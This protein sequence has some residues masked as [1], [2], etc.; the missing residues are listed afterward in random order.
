[1]Y[2]S[3][4]LAHLARAGRQHPF[5][6]QNVNNANTTALS[7]VKPKLGLATERAYFSSWG[8]NGYTANN[9][10][11]STNS[12]AA[13]LAVSN[14]DNQPWERDLGLHRKQFR[15][16]AGVRRYSTGSRTTSTD[17]GTSV[18]HD[19]P[20]QLQGLPDLK[21][22]IDE[23]A[24]DRN[25]EEGTVN[26]ET[27]K[28][29]FVSQEDEPDRQDPAPEVE[30]TY[31][32]K[33]KNSLES[34]LSTRF[35]ARD[36]KSVH[37]I[38]QEAVKS[39]DD[40][41]NTNTFNWLFDAL[42]RLEKQDKIMADPSDQ[43]SGHN[44]T[45]LSLHY[46]SIMLER[47]IRPD[48][49]TFT[50]ILKHLVDH[51][52]DLMDQRLI[53]HA[54]KPFE[55]LPQTRFQ[56]ANREAFEAAKAVDAAGTALQIFRAS[57]VGLDRTYDAGLLQNLLDCCVSEGY[58]DHAVAIYDYIEQ[59]NT[60]K[61]ASMYGALMMTFEKAR[62]L[63]GA[64][65]TF[66]TWKK[67][68][69][70]LPPHDFFLMYDSLIRCYF[71][72]G[73]AAGGLRF[74]LSAVGEKRKLEAIHYI[75][76]V[77][78]FADQ[79]LF[80][81]GL[82]FARQHLGD[83][84]LAF[85]DAI[86]E[87]VSSAYL[88]GHYGTARE[89]YK[90]VE[91]L[92]AFAR[93]PT[94]AFNYLA[95]LTI[96]GE[97]DEAKAFVHDCIRSKIELR[98][99]H[100]SVLISKYFAAGRISDAFEMARFVGDRR[101]V[102]NPNE[103]N[104]RK[105]DI[106]SQLFT[107]DLLASN[108]LDHKTTALAIAVLFTLGKTADKVV[109]IQFLEVAK[110]ELDMK[111]LASETET[112]NQ[113]CLYANNLMMMEP[114]SSTAVKEVQ[115][116]AAPIISWIVDALLLANDTGL[117][118]EPVCN[119]DMIAA[120]NSLGL[121]QKAAALEETLE[122]V[123][124]SSTS[125][126]KPLPFH[127][128][129]F[130]AL[131]D[132]AI[133]RRLSVQLRRAMNLPD[134]RDRRRDFQPPRGS[135]KSILSAFT[136]EYAADRPAIY[137]ETYCKAIDYYGK[138]GDSESLQRLLD[139]SDRLLPAMVNSTRH[140]SAA[141]AIIYDRAIKAFNDFFDNSSAQIYH[142]KILALGFA[143][144][145]DAYGS[146]IAKMNENVI[147][148]GASRAHQLFEEAVKIGVVPTDFLY[149]TLI[150]KLAKARRN[151]DALRYFQQM[152]DSG[153]APNGVT[154]GTVINSCCRVG[155]TEDAEALL[156]EMEALPRRGDKI[157]PYN[158]LMQHFVQVKKDRVKAL[159]YW[160]K[161]LASAIPPTGHS[162]RL[163]IEVYGRLDPVDPKAAESVLDMMR[164]N[165]LRIESIHVAALMVMY[166]TKLNDTKKAQALFDHWTNA[167]FRPD[168]ILYQ[169]LIETHVRSGQFAAVERCLEQM[170]LHRVP[171]TAYIANLAIEAYAAQNR[172]E[173]ARKC[174]D[175][176]AP[177]GSGKHNHGLAREPSTYE[178][179]IK[180]Y[181]SVNMPEKNAEILELI[182]VQGYPSAV[183]EKMQEL[184]SQINQ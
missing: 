8:S 91:S 38:M 164:S 120:A 157:A 127:R 26:H 152:K 64:I 80:K 142:D 181:N 163:L 137:G 19:V 161:L 15:S 76:V 170:D 14:D 83:S 146:F 150:G 54:H 173:D 47:R 160:N 147:R 104:R 101:A 28:D 184:V 138:F 168:A 81:E 183:V 148:D 24:K 66:N 29:V 111:L 3:P 1:M 149:N 12:P 93:K 88:Q 44:N 155:Q 110:K 70:D 178:A 177:D 113:L 21:T 2:K 130:R 16:I 68:C 129:I 167:E 30:K 105:L 180:A 43:I 85:S 46:Y 60:P 34:E 103:M 59:T 27:L 84:P 123:R 9:S 50:R 35:V 17:S 79:A 158:T 166:G 124:A 22:I 95:T 156:A 174:F 31:Q 53:L 116:R 7:L 179:M 23:A 118:T 90:Q 75:N 20:I 4:F 5:F 171:M 97:L 106:F 151:D 114:Y 125:I 122:K 37:D 132:D 131:S 87:M 58:V 18:G 40:R 55:N 154:Y 96:E 133:D 115:E 112:L 159:Y 51:R 39:K 67:N 153:I 11:A 45:A 145:A 176:L 10:A 140:L 56:D 13:I 41:L 135:D 92:A 42:H 52:V 77:K 100:I 109:Q 102:W 99:I 98:L 62:D 172:I 175:S 126:L 108:V 72:T 48:F 143:P 61:T 32:P 71:A 165:R 86:G 94:T 82:D 169:A 144:S 182:T 117:R 128:D 136:N 69:R 6:S 78:C 119:D 89:C 65:E 73:D 107:L 36:Y 121:T 25:V 49:Y 74:F 134:A 63:N 139:M 141:Q 57:V 162:Y 33:G